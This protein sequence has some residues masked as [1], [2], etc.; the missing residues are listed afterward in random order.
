MSAAPDL[1]RTIVSAAERIVAVR[2]E[3]EPQ[4]ALE[5][6]AAGVVP[7]GA[8]F[9][10]ELATAGRANV[11]AECK[12]RSPSKGVLTADYD[13]A[14]I[15][16]RYEEGGAAAISVLTEPTFF[17]GALEHLQA[18]RR[19]VALPLLRKDFIVDDYQLFEARAAGADAVLLIVAALEQ[20]ALVRLQRRAGEL[21]LAALVEVHDEEELS[22]AVDS[23]AGLI[24]VNNRNLRT[25]AVDVDASYRLAARMP[26]HVVAV[27]ESGLQ[28][29]SDLE[30]LAAAGYRAFL[31]GERFMTDP[32]PAGAIRG[33][34]EGPAEAG[35]YVP[36]G[37]R[38]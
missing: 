27:S 25:L 13:A 28:S 23:G 38:T 12:R 16:R 10:R 20:A 26:A 21:G 32:D 17:D 4:A 8:G 24:G 5:R 6:R 14:A 35:H 34:V 30:R 9:A 15:A 33:L 2:R 1:L 19:A 37:E 31:I 18:V 3:R 11:I 36:R 22:R 29:R 7:D